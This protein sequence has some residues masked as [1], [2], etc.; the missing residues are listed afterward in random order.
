MWDI[1]AFSFYPAVV[2][3]GLLFQSLENEILRYLK[4]ILSFMFLST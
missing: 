1:K 3:W 2:V 4:I